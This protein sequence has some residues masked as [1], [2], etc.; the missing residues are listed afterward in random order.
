MQ[1]FNKRRAIP[2]PTDNSTVPQT[3]LQANEQA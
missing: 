2:D 3:R 1:T